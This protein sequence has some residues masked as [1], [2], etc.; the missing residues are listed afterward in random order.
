MPSGSPPRSNNSPVRPL[1]TSGP[2]NLHRIIC[3]CVCICLYI[4]VYIYMYICIYIY[5]CIYV[6]IYVYMYICIYIYMYVYVYIYT[7]HI[8]VFI[9][10]HNISTYYIIYI[11]YINYKH[12]TINHRKAPQILPGTYHPEQALPE[13]VMFPLLN[14]RLGD[15]LS[16]RYRRMCIPS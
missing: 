16:V 14:R 7:Q 2:V 4:Y 5:I 1:V 15:V 9:Y 6:Y 8:Y 11:V 10:I 12:E 13:V 3:L